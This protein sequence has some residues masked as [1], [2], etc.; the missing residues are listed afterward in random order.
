MRYALKGTAIAVVIGLTLACSSGS[1]E[2][3]GVLV[4]RVA[5]T[6]AIVS[7]GESITLRLRNDGARTWGYNLCAQSRLQRFEQGAWVDMPPSLAQCT[8]VLF[9]LPARAVRTE[10]FFIPHELQPGLHRVRVQFRAAN[11][12]VWILSD[13]F[14]VR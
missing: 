9:T 2:P 5:A 7:R 3:I 1:T 11:D 4:P 12:E 8:A 14:E 6:S 13:A 10:E